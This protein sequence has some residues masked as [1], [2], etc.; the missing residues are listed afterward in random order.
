MS[1]TKHIKILYLTRGKV[2]SDYIGGDESCE[3][4]HIR[5]LS[6]KKNKVKLVRGGLLRLKSAKVFFA[7]CQMIII[8]NTISKPDKEKLPRLP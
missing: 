6:H 4:L 1:N 5:H 2:V 3:H 8:V 7:Q